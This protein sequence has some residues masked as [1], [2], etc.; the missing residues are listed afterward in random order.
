MA[1]QDSVNGGVLV[2]TVENEGLSRDTTLYSD[3]PEL[4]RASEVPSYSRLLVTPSIGVI[5]TVSGWRGVV[6]WRSVIV[7]VKE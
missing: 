2:W 6:V 4:V 5:V 3:P 7:F 1:H